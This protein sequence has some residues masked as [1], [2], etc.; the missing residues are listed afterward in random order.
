VIRGDVN[1]IRI[2][3]DTNLQDLC[4]LHGTTDVHPVRIGDGVTVG[5]A[6]VIHGATLEDGCLIGMRAVVLD[7]ARIGQSAMVAAGSVVPPGFEVPPRTL[8]LGSP[9]RVKRPLRP[10]ELR[11]LARSAEHYAELAR[12]HARELGLVGE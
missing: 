2:G 8:A 4:V 1:F 9:A 7:G 5:H 11:E 12:L 6:A 10:E 3:R